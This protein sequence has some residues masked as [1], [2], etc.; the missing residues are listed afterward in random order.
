VGERSDRET[1]EDW[2]EIGLRIQRQ[3]NGLLGFSQRSAISLTTSR[4]ARRRSGRLATPTSLDSAIDFSGYR[5]GS[6]NKNREPYH[7][8]QVL[9]V[10]RL[11]VSLKAI[12][13]A[14]PL[15]KTN[16]QKGHGAQ[17]RVERLAAASIP[18]SSATLRGLKCRMAWLAAF[19][20]V[21]EAPLS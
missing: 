6:P 11:Q 7:K 17:R 15:L 1:D 2:S 4:I 9:V 19:N 16:P 13:L 3:R 14:Y 5:R 12:D 18:Q 20:S 8:E 21:L 10:A